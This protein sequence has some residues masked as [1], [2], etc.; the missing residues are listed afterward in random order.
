M[1]SNIRASPPLDAI[2]NREVL[3][4]QTLGTE[5]SPLHMIFG[6]GDFV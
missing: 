1:C 2:L 6:E 4:R 5:S 3:A